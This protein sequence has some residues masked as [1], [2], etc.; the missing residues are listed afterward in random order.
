MFLQQSPNIQVGG[1]VVPGEITLM[2][3]HLRLNRSG[4]REGHFILNIK[5]VFEFSIIFLC[6]NLPSSLRFYELSYD[7]DTIPRFP[8]TSL[9]NVSDTEFATDLL[10]VR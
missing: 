1:A 5:D 8:D 3:I 9:Q 4:N 2:Q 7:A 10:H 6:P